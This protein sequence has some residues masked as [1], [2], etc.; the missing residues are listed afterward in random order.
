ML[1]S[2]YS[3]AIV[4][5]LTLQSQR[6]YDEQDVGYLGKKFYGMWISLDI[7]KEN[8]KFLNWN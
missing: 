4:V 1:G 6:A 5:V 8:C 7:E 2:K 3:S